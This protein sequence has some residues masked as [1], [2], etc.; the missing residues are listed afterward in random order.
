[1]PEWPEPMHVF[2]GF[3]LKI[4]APGGISYAVV[5]STAYGAPFRSITV[6]DAI[7]EL[8]PVENGSSKLTIE[9]NFLLFTNYHSFD[10]EFFTVSYVSINDLDLAGIDLS[11]FVMLVI[12]IVHFYFLLLSGSMEAIPYCGF[13]SISGEI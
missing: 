9:V 5:P 11:D 6:R 7:G 3:E 1:M 4:A 2:A 13:K 12:Y 8:P 10:M